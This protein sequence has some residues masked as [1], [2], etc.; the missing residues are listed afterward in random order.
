MAKTFGNRWNF[1]HACGAIDGKHVAIKKPHQSGSVYYNN[2]GFCSI[3]LLGLVDADYK[4]LWASAGSN[5]S[6]SDAG[7]FSECSLC[8]ALEENNI[9]FPPAEPLTQDD[10]NIPILHTGR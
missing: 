9:G 10:R 6:A 8:A 3:V 1:N 5:G 2:N 4:F 7:I